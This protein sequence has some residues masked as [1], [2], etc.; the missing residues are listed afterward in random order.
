MTP[1]CGCQTPSMNRI[2]HLEQRVDELGAELRR[3]EESADS[4][5]AATPVPG[6]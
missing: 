5:G 3:L 2:E 4:S 1:C 6:G